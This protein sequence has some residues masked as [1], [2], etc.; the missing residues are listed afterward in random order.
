MISNVSI[1]GGYVAREDQ[2]T[3]AFLHLLEL[4]GEKLLYD[5]LSYKGFP[6]PTPL[7]NVTCQYAKRGGSRPDGAIANSYNILF[8][9]KIVRFSKKD[10][11]QM[12]AHLNKLTMTPFN[13]LI[14]I[15]TDKTKPRALTD[16]RI[17]WYN[18]TEICDIYNQFSV[19][20]TTLF[21]YLCAE[22]EK[23]LENFN[24]IDNN[25]SDRVLIVGGK[26]GGG[27]AKTYGIYL[28]QQHRKFLPSKYIAFYSNY[29]IQEV[30][31]IVEELQDQDLSICNDIPAN[32]IQNEEPH[33]QSSDRR[34]VFVLKPHLTNLN[35]KSDKKSSTGKPCAFIQSHTYTTISKISTAKKT[36]QL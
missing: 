24:I 27:V 19:Q 9:M 6:S 13:Y 22:F 2:V 32:Y 20:A 15:T 34:N 7:L 11:H 21:Q 35:I 12:N 5:L 26:K 14:Y 17:V 3:S 4:G 28:Y 30:Y 23:L 8:E 16:Q 25:F 31:E 1:L 33:Y 18:W 10:I 36:S 29:L